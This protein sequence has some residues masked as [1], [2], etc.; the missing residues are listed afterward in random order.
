MT[1]VDYYRED[2][3]EDPCN[4]VED[5]EEYEDPEEKAELIRMINLALIM[6]RNG[7]E[8]AK[9]NAFSGHIRVTRFLKY[10]GA[11]VIQHGYKK[12]LVPSALKRF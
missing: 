11:Y 6:K 3:D 4:I 2:E 5:D 1:A 7:I 9:N 10:I 12:N 8:I